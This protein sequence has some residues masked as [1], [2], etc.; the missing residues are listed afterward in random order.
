MARL[1]IGRALLRAAV[2]IESSFVSFI[3][4]A[5][6]F[7]GKYSV[8]GMLE[9]WNCVAGKASDAGASSCF[10][11]FRVL[12]FVHRVTA[13]AAGKASR[14]G[15]PCYGMSYPHLFH[16]SLQI[17]KLASFQLRAP[18]LARVCSESSFVHSSSL[19]IVPLASLQLWAPHLARVCSESSF[20]HSSSLQ[21][22]PL[23]R[24]HLRASAG[25]CLSEKIICHSS[26]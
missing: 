7:S 24:F 6:C 2:F 16:S 15:S 12:L 10:S 14:F 5:D 25:V 4:T 18:L 23:A 1:L 26:L 11:L 9:C 8:S 17:A 19:Q 21:I 22:A 20:V 13:C 3:V